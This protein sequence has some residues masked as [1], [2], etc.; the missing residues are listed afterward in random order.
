MKIIDKIKKAQEEKKVLFSFEYFPPK[1]PEG[2]KNLY[3]RMDRMGQL[4]PTW[5]DVTWGA[6]GSTSEL[7]LEICKTAQNL[8]GLETMMHLTCTNLPVAKV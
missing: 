1:T 2:V 3:E 5:I 8:C 4:E 7:T 6:G